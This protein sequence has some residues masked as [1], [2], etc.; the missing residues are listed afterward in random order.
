MSK[1][2]QK[3]EMGIKLGKKMIEDIPFILAAS[4]PGVGGVVEWV[5]GSWDSVALEAE[6]EK[7]RK[8]FVLNEEAT[9]NNEEYEMKNIECIEVFFADYIETDDEDFVEDLI[10]VLTEINE[11]CTVQ[12]TY[13]CVS[14]Y[15][16]LYE[17]RIQIQLE[18]I[19]TREYVEEYIE[20]IESGIS[21]GWH[22]E[23]PI[24]KVRY[25]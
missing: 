22:S 6:L 20:N 21:N 4:L 18:D 24:S 2:N 7:F 16:V 13:G 8:K 1:N 3:K 10:N 23:S 19:Y 5:K 15:Y 25:Y 9:F 17:D 14:K 11:E 12:G